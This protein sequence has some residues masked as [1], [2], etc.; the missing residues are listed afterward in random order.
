MREREIKG[1]NLFYTEMRKEGRGYKP[2]SGL[3][4]AW[5]SGVKTS[6]FSTKTLES[7]YDM[8]QI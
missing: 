3:I 4:P 2:A 6:D 7:T 1:A 8:H 5:A